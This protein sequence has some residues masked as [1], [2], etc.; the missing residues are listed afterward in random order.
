MATDTVDRPPEEAVGPL[1]RGIAVIR[2]LTD[3]GAQTSSELARRVGLARASLDR[4]LATL[5]ELDYVRFDRDQVTLAPALM[6]LGNTYLHS[7]RVPALLGPL[8]ERLSERLDEIVTLT[9]PDHDGAH[10]VAEAV[11][12]RTLVIACH[13][14]DRLPLDRCAVGALFASTWDDRA[15]DRFAATHACSRESGDR[16]ACLDDLRTRADE[17]RR[18]GWALDDQWLEPGLVAVSVPVHGPDGALACTVNVLS[19][20]SRHATAGELADTVLPAVQETVRC[21][22]EALCAAPGPVTRPPARPRGAA[23]PRTVESLARGLDVLAAFGAATPELTIADAGRATGLPRATVR[24]ALITLEYLGYVTH[25]GGR[26]RPTPAVLSLG[27][28]VLSRMT[29]AQLAL[30]HLRSLSA[31]VGDS[32]SLAVLHDDTEIMYR[33]RAANSE[34]LTAID[35]HVGTRLPAYP[36]AAGRVLLAALPEARR[37]RAVPA[38]L[39]QQVRHDGYAVVDEQLEAGLRSVAVPVAGPDGVAVAAV[40]VAMHAGR[41]GAADS[42]EQILPRLRSAAAAIHRDLVAVGAFHRPT[43]M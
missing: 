18:Q 11:R 32:V 12:P 25:T 1:M 37:P 27:A 14:G 30:P 28:T 29:L 26:Y 10:L 38:A 22:A 9:V 6:A 41:D 15:W 42:V 23:A 7:V 4:V 20:T 34:R 31:D 43:M 35:I 39:C 2:A 13:V 16:R 21:M 33:A 40:D 5:S 24:R 8:A 3:D 17:A 19:F 36:T